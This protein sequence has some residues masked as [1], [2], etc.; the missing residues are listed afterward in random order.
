MNVP[1]LDIKAQYAGI[2]DQVLA[3]LAQVVD[4]YQFTNVHAPQVKD[5]E[6][7]L[8]EYCGCK[9]AFGVSSGTDAILCALMALEI[10]PGDEVIVPP[11]TFFATAGCVSR[12]GAKPVFVDIQE[13]TFNIDPA[14]IEAAITPRTRAILPV[15]LYGQTAEMDAILDIAR[16]HKLAVIE[17]AAQAIGAQCKGRKAGAMGTI[18]CFS[19]YPTKNLGAMGD[20]GFVTTQDVALAERMACLRNHGETSQYHHKFVGGC[21]RLDVMQA[22]VLLVKLPHLEGWSAARRA[23]AAR[24]ERLLAP[25]K[26][27]RTP[28]VRKGNTSI[29]N[30]YVIRAQR[31]DELKAYLQAK[32]IGSVIYYPVLHEQECFKPLGYKRGDFPVSERT[33]A[34]VLA[35]PIYAELPDAQLEYVAA[36]IR[37]F[38]SKA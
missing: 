6:A 7:R 21:F 8:A 20:G 2:K 1:F 23:N 14:K 27:V 10:G 9:Y 35:L 22:G 31:R 26:Q 25:C 34:E 38:Y 33:A 19:F 18:G 29:F 3:A 15:H 30:Q 5:L 12:V 13:D 32:E 37:E 24:Y 16:R 36:T 4:S 11:F 17:D 28:V